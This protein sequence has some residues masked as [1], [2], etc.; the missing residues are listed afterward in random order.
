MAG[1]DA[2]LA[3]ADWA[4]SKSGGSMAKRKEEQLDRFIEQA[5]QSNPE[6]T[7]WF[8][9]RTKFTNDTGAYLWS[10]SDN[11]WGTHPHR[12]INPTTGEPVV[13]CV[14]SETDILVVFSRLNSGPFALHIE[15][16]LENGSFKI[17]Q[18]ERYRSR[19]THWLNNPKYRAYVDFEIILIAP[20]IF[21]ERHR[22]DAKKFDRHISHE[23]IANYLPEFR[24]ISR[25]LKSRP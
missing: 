10:R 24:K 20:E 7:S 9:S 14:Q 6:F 19:A 25:E 11:P 18:P 3:D 2:N 4:T 22:D 1:L 12:T 13:K 21:L 17:E 5:F 8:L 15:N 16:K 23:D